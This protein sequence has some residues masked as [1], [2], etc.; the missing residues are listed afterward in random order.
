MNHALRAPLMWTIVFGLAVL[1]GNAAARAQCDVVPTFADGIKPTREIHVAPA[2]S[3]DD[4]SGNGSSD[5]PY[6]TIAH[7]ASFATPGTS[8]RLRPGTYRG[9]AYLHRLQGTAAAPIWIGGDP[10]RPGEAAWKRPVIEGGSQGLHLSRCAYVVVQNLEIRNVSANGINSDDGAEYDNP[11]SAHHQVFRSLFIHDVGS[12]GNQDGLKLSG[13]YDFVVLDCE[14]AR[15]GGGMSGSGIDMVG[16]HR[17]VIANSFM[18]DLSANAVQAKGGT[19]D[20]EI[21]RCRMVD[22]GE[23]AINIGGSTGFEFFRPPLSKDEVNAEAR[24][25]RAVSNLIIGSNAAVAFVGAVE[26]IAS[27]NTI[28]NPRRWVMRILQET[29]ST[30]PYEFA[31]SSNNTFMNNI[32]YYE[33]AVI[34]THVNIGGDTSPATFTFANNLWFAHDNPSR[35]G[36]SLPVPE[37]DGIIGKDPAFLSVEKGIYSIGPKSPAVGAGRGSGVVG[38]ATGDFAGNCYADPPSIGAFEGR[39]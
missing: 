14:I 11:T 24:N 10:P 37:Q 21:S 4:Q 29:R 13:I 6:A 31:P 3:G 26:C 22:A 5:K 9:G 39:R 20:I 32:V 27:N 38:R 30:P 23:R 15:C 33:R 16:C 28:I 7:A 35:S 12:N 25:V 34:A 19:S 2:P 36:P 8:I 1:I 17:G 18:H